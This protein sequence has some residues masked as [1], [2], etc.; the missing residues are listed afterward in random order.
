MDTANRNLTPEPTVLL[1]LDVADTD[2]P[3]FNVLVRIAQAFAHGRGGD[4]LEYAAA[5]ALLNAAAALAEQGGFELSL[6]DVRLARMIGPV[7]E[8]VPFGDLDVVGGG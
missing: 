6:D 2:E 4:E 7:F 3:T 8:A 1:T 5:L